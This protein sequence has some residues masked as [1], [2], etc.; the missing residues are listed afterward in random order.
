MG[1]KYK[2]VEE[3]NGVFGAVLE[4][5]NATITEATTAGLKS[6]QGVREEFCT[7]AKLNARIK[8]AG[9]ANQ[10]ET[11]RLEQIR[12]H[13]AEMNRAAAEQKKDNKPFLGLDR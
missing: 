5:P 9:A 8:L 3:R 10:E 6:T 12:D 7:E 1:F 11:A 4:Y 13:V 2:G